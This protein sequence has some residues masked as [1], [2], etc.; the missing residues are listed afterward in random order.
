MCVGNV[1][2]FQLPWRASER[3][4]F[5]RSLSYRIST[6]K[7]VVNKLSSTIETDIIQR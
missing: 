4:T 5:F 1:L 3:A 2:K 6:E 7:C